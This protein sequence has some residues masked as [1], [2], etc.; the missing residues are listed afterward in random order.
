MEGKN[1][2]PI[3]TAQY[4]A[5]KVQFEWYAA[6][7]INHS[8]DSVI[9]NREVALFFVEETRA[10]SRAYPSPAVEAGALIYNYE[11]FYTEVASPGFEQCYFFPATQ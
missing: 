11:A 10:N 9:A 8:Y 2:L 3:F 1:G 6:E 5:E 7:V 4:H